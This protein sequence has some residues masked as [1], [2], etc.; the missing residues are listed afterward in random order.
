MS[1][2]MHRAEAHVCPLA[3]AGQDKLNCPSPCTVYL[4]I[5]K[6]NLE[7]ASLVRL[8]GPVSPKVH[9]LSGL[10]LSCRL[11]G[12]TQATVIAVIARQALS[13]S[14]YRV[15]SLACL[16]KTSSGG[17]HESGPGGGSWA[18][19]SAPGCGPAGYLKTTASAPPG[20][21]SVL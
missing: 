6:W 13:L 7:L 19:R 15:I 11:Y 2:H 16:L 8:C 18:L 14:S 5:L 12:L 10:L 20:S 21:L 4:T 9:T 17:E 1:V 3:C